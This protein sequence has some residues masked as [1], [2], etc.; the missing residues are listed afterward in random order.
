MAAEGS[1][2]LGRWNGGTIS[3]NLGLIWDM[4]VDGYILALHAAVLAAALLQAA[5]GI[6]FG[7]IAGPIILM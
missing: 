4:A 7:I 3:A 6:G 5:T 2:Y 1:Q